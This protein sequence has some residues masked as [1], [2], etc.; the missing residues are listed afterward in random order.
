MVTGSVSIPII[1]VAFWATCNRKARI[2]ECNRVADSVSRRGRVV[3]PVL[4]IVVHSTLFIC[5]PLSNTTP[6]S[7]LSPAL[8]L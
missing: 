3:L 2:R 4:S 5:L 8:Q 6:K 1:L 7:H